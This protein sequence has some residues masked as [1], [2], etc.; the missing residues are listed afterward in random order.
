MVPS[1]HQP[2][3]E[4]RQSLNLPRAVNDSSRH[5][6]YDPELAQ[7]GGVVDQKFAL[8]QVTIRLPIDWRPLPLLALVLSFVPWCVPAILVID[9]ACTRDASA[10]A[11]LVLFVATVCV[12]EFLMKPLLDQPR[13]STSACRGPNGEMLPGMPSGHVVASQ[14]LATWYAMRAGFELPPSDAA[15]AII[16]LVLFMCAVPW[17]RWYNGDHSFWQVLAAA[18]YSTPLA[19][20]VYLVYHFATSPVHDLKR[21]L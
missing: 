3:S 11:L 13:P 18:V 5:P 7:H 12:N 4:A 21:G 6:S 2:D 14:T 1:Q 10:I 15:W 17:A 20:A 8:G 16:G 19:A 9:I